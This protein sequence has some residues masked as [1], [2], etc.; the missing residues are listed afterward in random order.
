MNSYSTANTAPYYTLHKS[1]GKQL[2]ILEDN[3]EFN[4]K[5][6]E[7]NLSTKELFTIKTE[8]AELNAWMI[9]PPNFDKT[10]EQWETKF[11][12]NDYKR[13]IKLRYDL[14]SSKDNKSL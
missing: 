7:Y 4:K 9:K 6:E 14:V 1:N 10:K 13:S 11:N 2:K 5:M 12:P 8:D 3:A